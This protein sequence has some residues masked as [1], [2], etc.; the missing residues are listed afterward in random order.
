VA[1][2]LVT[3]KVPG[4]GIDRL[5]EDGHDVDLWEG[6]EAPPRDELLKR[7]AEA[8]GLLSMLVDRV[9][10]ELF[11]AAPSLRAVSNYAVGTDNVDLEEATRRGI[12]VGHT[13]DVLTDATADLAW[14]LLMAGARRLGEA[15]RFV[16]AGKW[17]TWT[18]D[19]FL[20]VD[21]HG[22]CLGVI[23]WGRIAQAFARRAEGFDMEVMY[24][25][26]SSGIP[27]DELLEK[28]DFVS[29]HAPL[30]GETRGL[31][32]ARELELMKPT[33]VLINTA[34]GELVDTTALTEALHLGTIG[35]A[36]LDVTDPEPLP[37]DHPLLAA[38]NITVVPHIGSATTR[39]RAAM[40][41]M[42]AENLIAALAG[43]RMPYVAN[44]DVYDR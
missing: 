21:V 9:D 24:H 18:P 36:A 6:R 1:R 33:A 32:G 27:L 17:G 30:T 2:I 38:P 13:P 4:D 25:S 39:T 10:S 42:A 14:A 35:G 20:G 12:P 15:E 28:S 31:I 23:G 8:E 29:L 22:A 43:E 19:A 44:P 11:D 7:V 16:R 34:R 41:E 3:R 26:R 37:G 5:R 40:G